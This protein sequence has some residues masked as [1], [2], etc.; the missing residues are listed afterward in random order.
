MDILLFYL[1]E[2]IDIILSN[3]DDD[4]FIDPSS[5]NIHVD[6]DEDSENEEGTILDNLSGHQLFAPAEIR[7]TSNYKITKEIDSSQY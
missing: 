4:L 6:T 1:T 7:L 3:E 2:E 5:H